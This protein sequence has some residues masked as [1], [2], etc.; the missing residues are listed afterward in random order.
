[1]DGFDKIFVVLK[2]ALILIFAFTTMVFG[3]LLFDDVQCY[4]GIGSTSECFV[5]P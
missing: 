1:M 4:L 3:V 2:G 5:N